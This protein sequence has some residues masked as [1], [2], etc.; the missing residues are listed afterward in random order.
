[1]NVG[2]DCCRM[3][4]RWCFGGMGFIKEYW[5][6]DVGV[7]LGSILNVMVFFLRL[8]EFLKVFMIWDDGGGKKF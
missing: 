7:I 3:M 4:K 5:R 2:L 1:M 6:K 8:W